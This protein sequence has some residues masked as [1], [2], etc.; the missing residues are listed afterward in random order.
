M[1]GREGGVCIGVKLWSRVERVVVVVIMGLNK[2]I[3][4]VGRVPSGSG[5][6]M[7]DSVF[8]C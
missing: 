5:K 4:K 6:E 1:D 8:S 7:K 3:N 2:F